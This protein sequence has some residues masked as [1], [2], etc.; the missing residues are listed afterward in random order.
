MP[1]KP[2]PRLIDDEN[3]EWTDEAFARA[4]PAG[5]VLVEQ[6]GA[7]AAARLLKPKRGRPVKA[8]PKRPTNIRF[9]P[10][11][12]AHFRATGKGWQTR[13]DD[14]LKRHVA[15]HARKPSATKRISGRR[16]ARV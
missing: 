7:E 3:P 13:M 14:V 1:R 8:T 15:R 4:R 5:E 6:L 12:L 16:L 11:V 2:N 10:E 9:S